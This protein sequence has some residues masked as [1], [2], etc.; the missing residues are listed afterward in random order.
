MTLRAG[1]PEDPIIIGAMGTQENREDYI[2]LAHD[3]EKGAKRIGLIL[4]VLWV[5]VLITVIGLIITI[6]TG[7]I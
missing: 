4:G 6:L 2:E 5:G 3:L 7:K 1:T